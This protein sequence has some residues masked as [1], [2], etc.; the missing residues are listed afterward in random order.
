MGKK[1]LRNPLA[2]GA[3]REIHSVPSHITAKIEALEIQ[4]AAERE[5]Q[6]Q[7]VEKEVLRDDPAL[8]EKFNQAMRELGKLKSSIASV[9]EGAAVKLVEVEKLVEKIVEV[10]RIVRQLSVVYVI[11]K[12]KAALV[13][14]LGAAASQLAL[15]VINKL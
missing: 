8:L 13:F 3:V 10:P 2:N 6:L 15:Y 7:V 11:S 14:C 9:P 5:R 12:R 1:M 4:L